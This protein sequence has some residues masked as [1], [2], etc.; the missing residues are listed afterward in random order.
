MT[1]IGPPSAISAGDSLQFSLGQ[2]TWTILLAARQPGTTTDSLV[3]SA[4]TP[5]TVVGRSGTVLEVPTTNWVHGTWLWQATRS[6]NNVNSTVATGEVMLWPALSPSAVA[7]GKFVETRTQ[8][9]L[10][11]I[12]LRETLQRWN[13]Q[14]W[15]QQQAIQ[16]R[17]LSRYTL[18]ELRDLEQMYALRV[19]HERQKRGLRVKSRYVTMRPR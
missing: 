13:D 10:N 2:G 5:E 11:L 12:K 19:R 17:S 1:T 16:G 8:N 18:G 14:G 3:R 6:L 7:G 9:E 4:T 15:V